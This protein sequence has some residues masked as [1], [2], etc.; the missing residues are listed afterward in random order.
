MRLSCFDCCPLVV[1]HVGSSA[2]VAHIIAEEWY[3]YPV[4]YVLRFYVVSTT[5]L[6]RIFYVAIIL[7]PK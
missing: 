3:A 7:L 6:A 2:S 1:R 4:L 5:I